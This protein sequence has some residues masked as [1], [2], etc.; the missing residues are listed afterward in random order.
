MGQK[1][2]SITNRP[3]LTVCFS[4]RKIWKYGKDFNFSYNKV[5]GLAGDL[6]PLALG[7]VGQK[8]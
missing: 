7:T 4:D 2:E 5:D 1:E 8:I 3:T 6:N